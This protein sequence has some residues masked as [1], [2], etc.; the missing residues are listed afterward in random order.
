MGWTCSSSA[1]CPPGC[2][3]RRCGPGGPA[4]AERPAAGGGAPAAL[5]EPLGVAPPRAGLT[6]LAYL[7]DL[8][9]RYLADRQEQAGAPLGAP[10]RWLLPALAAAVNGQPGTD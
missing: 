7:A 6:A 2:S 5:R 8:S 3:E 1:R 4:P 10:R 9:V